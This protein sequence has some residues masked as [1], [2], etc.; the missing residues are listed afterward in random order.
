MEYTIQDVAIKFN[1]SP[2]TLRY[3]DKEGLLPFITRNHAGN[4][5]FS[6]VDLN[7]LGLI[8]CLKDTGM[9]IKEIKQYSDWC[10]LGS[11]TIDSRKDMLIR[12]RETVTAQIEELKANLKLIDKKIESYL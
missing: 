10:K 6:D 4:R 11:G 3:Y 8:I 9:P 12:H 2:H 5:V 7:W 1:L